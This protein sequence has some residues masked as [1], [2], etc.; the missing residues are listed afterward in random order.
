MGMRRIKI[1]SIAVSFT[2]TL[3]NNRLDESDL[4]MTV[5]R[6]KVL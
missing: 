3:Y 5:Q 2:R 1:I 6:E 4:Q